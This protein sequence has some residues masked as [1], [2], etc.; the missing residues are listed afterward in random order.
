M[1][2]VEIR[3]GEVALTL[4]SAA[5]FFFLLSGYF[6]L[7]PLRDQVGAG[8]TS[9]E[10]AWLFTGTLAVMLLAMPAYGWL[11]SRWPRR[12]FIPWVYR[13]FALNLLAFFVLWKLFP[14][15]KPGPISTAFFIW[16][17]VFNMF[18]VSVFWSFMADVFKLEQ[19]KRL[20]GMVAVGGSLG[21]IVG[22]LL[23]K[24]LVVT[25]G[26]ANMLLISI[27]F[28]EIATQCMSWIARLRGFGNEDPTQLV[29]PAGAALEAAEQGDVWNGLRLV[30]RSPYL[31]LIALHFLLMSMLGT[32]FYVEQSQMVGA[33]FKDAGERTAFLAGIDVWTNSATLATQLLLTGAVVKRFG[34]GIALLIQPV[35][36]VAALGALGIWNVLPV[37]VVG[38]ATL[39]TL[40][41]SASRPAREMLFTVVGREV[42]YKAKSIVDTVV[43]RLGDQ[44][45]VWGSA[46]LKTASL[47][48]SLLAGIAVPLAVV[49]CAVAVL[50]GR[51]QRR[52]AREEPSAAPAP[53]HEVRARA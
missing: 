8:R 34:I 16:V 40:Q 42:K 50:L 30:L 35:V 32:V 10:L 27:A 14:E 44:L 26:T 49:W 1:K 51:M 24:Q 45:G 36:C 48:L 52:L 18:V 46:W 9:T 20:F 6:I 31:M 5:Y 33:A 25:L 17:S 22:G 21:A 4:L 23:T 13:F 28:L 29:T 2:L 47:S 38:Q 15:P 19:S 53:E 41:N 7:R 39:R 3:K 43:V 12:R 11:V 37:L